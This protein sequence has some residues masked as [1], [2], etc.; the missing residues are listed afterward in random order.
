MAYSFEGVSTHPDLRIKRGISYIDKYGAS[1][2][3]KDGEEGFER[4]FGTIKNREPLQILPSSREWSIRGVISMT[5]N[6]E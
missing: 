2:D 5:E 6:E 4:A 3:K 1:I